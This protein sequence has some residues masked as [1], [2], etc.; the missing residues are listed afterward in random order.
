MI[1]I[2]VPIPVPVATFSFGGW[3]DSLFGDVKAHGAEGV[4]FFTQ[5]K[6]I[7]SRWPDPGQDQSGA[8]SLGFPENE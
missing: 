8:L 4:R 2:N 1:G 5:L 3:K 6:A 7:T